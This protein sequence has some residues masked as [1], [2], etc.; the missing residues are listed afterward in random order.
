MVSLRRKKNS[1]IRE[2]QFLHP[3]YYMCKAKNN[4]VGHG[5]L[6]FEGK[7]NFLCMVYTAI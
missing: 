1:T 4:Y 5:A 7:W 6:A 2:G 3:I